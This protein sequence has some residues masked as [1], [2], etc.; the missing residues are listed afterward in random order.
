MI[1]ELRRLL[2]TI[3]RAKVLGV[4]VFALIVAG[5]IVWNLDFIQGVNVNVQMKGDQS[6]ASKPPKDGERK[7]DSASLEIVKVQVTPVR[8]E[9]GNYIYFR[10]AHK[11]GNTA[12]DVAITIDLGPSTTIERELRQIDD[13]KF[14]TPPNGSYQKI[15]C[16]SLSKGSYVDALLRVSE[17]T[18]SE[19]KAGGENVSIP[20]EALFRGDGVDIKGDGLQLKWLTFL[21]FLAAIFVVILFVIL[22]LKT[23]GFFFRDW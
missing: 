1:E 2:A 18:F 11:H 21:E 7:N 5:L 16:N 13:C 20:A 9:R 4:I 12:R 6:E 19:I 22:I 15:V 3:G 8:F 23:L 17:P 10:V 14:T